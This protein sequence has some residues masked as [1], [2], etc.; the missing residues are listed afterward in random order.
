MLTNRPVKH[1]WWGVAQDGVYFV[2][3]FP[4]DPAHNAV[5]PGPK[6]VYRLNP[7]TGAITEVAAITGRVNPDTPDFCVSPDGKVLLYSLLEVS[8]S[9]IRMIAGLR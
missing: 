4:N 9:Q 3:L 7:N 1:G 6:P 5:S 8:T 2:D